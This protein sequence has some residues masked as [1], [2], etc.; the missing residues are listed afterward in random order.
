MD[1]HELYERTGI[2]KRKL[3][4]CLD[5]GLVPGLPIEIA[6]DEVGR[7]RKFN[8]DV[9]FGIVCAARL[10][11]TG[12]PHQRI[13]AFLGGLLQIQMKGKGASARAL[14][15]I[16]SS[17]AV[18][19]AQAHLGDGRYVRLMASTTTVQM[20][21]SGWQTLENSSEPPSE[22]RP[23]VEVILDIGLILQQV[24]DEG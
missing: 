18:T 5:H 17:P 15:A 21:D 24:R 14:P 4:Y 16:L 11:Q 7:P 12:L 6:G 3:R 22:Y 9:G 19:K 10:L 13:R 23:T 20:W 1:L 2:P 8:W